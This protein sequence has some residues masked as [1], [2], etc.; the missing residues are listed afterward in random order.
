MV[1]LKK[2]K[3]RITKREGCFT[4]AIDDGFVTYIGEFAI[5]D[6]HSIASLANM[7]ERI[8]KRKPKKVVYSLGEPE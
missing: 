4:I 2:A 8:G 3:K 6:N 1:E 5:N 7:I